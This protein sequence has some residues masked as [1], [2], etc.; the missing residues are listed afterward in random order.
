MSPMPPDML[1]YHIN[2]NILPR[3]PS[4][5]TPLQPVQINTSQTKE[6]TTYLSPVHLRTSH[7]T[8]RNHFPIPQIQGVVPGFRR[9]HHSA[10][11]SHSLS[12]PTPTTRD[13]LQTIN[14]TNSLPIPETTTQPPDLP[15]TQS[16]SYPRPSPPNFLH[17]FSIVPYTT[18]LSTTNYITATENAMSDSPHISL[19]TIL[20][21]GLKLVFLGTLCAA[22]LGFAWTVMVCC[23]VCFPQRRE[24]ELSVEEGAWRSSE[25][26]RSSNNR[27]QHSIKPQPEKEGMR[28]VANNP[29]ADLANTNGDSDR[30]GAVSSGLDIPATP[31][32]RRQNNASLVSP[33]DPFLD[34]PVEEEEGWVR[35]ERTEREWERARAEFFGEG[36]AGD[37]IEMRDLS[38]VQVEPVRKRNSGGSSIAAGLNRGFEMLDVGVGMVDGVVDDV[39]AAVARWTDDEG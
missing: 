28:D 22:A 10:Q 24:A 26:R 29:F 34:P 38:G 36:I 37:E 18:L 6:T 39:V 19:A 13:I 16:S 33:R 35:V 4:S 9:A 11:S 8:G 15:K 12:F 14:S 31:R 5:R 25:V 17:P 30:S 32:Y 7:T 3:P 27:T 2:Q 20:P 21:L 23:V 1:A